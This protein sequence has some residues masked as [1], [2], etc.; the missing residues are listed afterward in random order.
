MEEVELFVT[1][2]IRK[3]ASK[4][5][6]KIV[7]N[8]NLADE[9]ESGLCYFSHDYCECRKLNNTFVTAVYTDKLKDILKNLDFNSKISNPYLLL[10]ALNSSLI[11][12]YDISYYSPQELFPENWKQL[13]EKANFIEDKNKNIA[14]SDKFKCKKCKE[15]RSTV[16]QIQTRSSDEPMTT[17]ITCCNCGHVLKF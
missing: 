11:I 15:R 9:I 16:R 5:L 6:E 1:D 8:E 4:Q 17:F 13:I 12:P 7:K 14:V 2:D 3:N 10:E